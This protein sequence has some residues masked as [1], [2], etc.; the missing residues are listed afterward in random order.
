V[1]PL[2]LADVAEA[3]GGRLAAQLLVDALG[4]T[5]VAS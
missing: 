4:P 5:G 2:T 3:V 1:I